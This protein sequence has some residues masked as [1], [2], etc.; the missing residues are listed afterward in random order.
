[1]EHQ[2]NPDFVWD[3]PQGKIYI[4]IKGYFQDSSEASKYKWVK[5]ALGDNEELIFIFE[6]PDKALHY[7]CKRKDGSKM[8]MAQWAEKNGFRWFTIESFKEV[9]V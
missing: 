9:F 8:T 2:Y 5:E 4:E 6:D 1:M 7:L 3:S